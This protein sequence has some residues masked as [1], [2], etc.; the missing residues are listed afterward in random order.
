MND[1]LA[2]INQVRAN[3]PKHQPTK[4][5]LIVMHLANL[6]QYAVCI[7]S[8]AGTLVIGTAEKDLEA[9]AKFTFTHR[10]MGDAVEAIYGLEVA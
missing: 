7:R 5:Q 10:V 9:F 3:Q 1:S 4:P 2:Y 6:N 8:E